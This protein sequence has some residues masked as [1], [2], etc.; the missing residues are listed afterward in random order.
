MRVK[1]MHGES[2]ILGVRVSDV[3]WRDPQRRVRCHISFAWNARVAPIVLS[4]VIRSHFA[5]HS[6]PIIGHAD[7][8]WESMESGEWECTLPHGCRAQ[9]CVA[10]TQITG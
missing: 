3:D 7:A 5:R 6:W 1:T 2:G 9:F 10:D 4:F 8:A